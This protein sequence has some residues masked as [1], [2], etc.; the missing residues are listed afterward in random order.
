[1]VFLAL[2][3]CKTNNLYLNVMEP[4]PVTIPSYIKSVGVINRSIPTDK[5][6]AIDALEKV[7][8]LESKD[9]DRYGAQEA[10]VG[11]TEELSANNRFTDVKTLDKIDFRTSALEIFPSPLSWEI[12]A[13]ICDETGTNA[14]FSLEKFDTDTHVNYSANK[15]EIKTPLGSIPGN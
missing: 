2:V 15:V 11:L 6:Q 1:M 14:L 9:L 8:T 3:S 10:I 13:Q 5:T 7:L 12:V 4:A